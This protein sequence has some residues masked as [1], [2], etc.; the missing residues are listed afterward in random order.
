MRGRNDQAEQY[1]KRSLEINERYYGPEH[2]VV[3]DSLNELGYLYWVL[4]RYT[5][6]EALQRRE[7]AIRE[8]TLGT[9]HTTLATA[10]KRLA[11][12]L[13]RT[14]RNA[15]APPFA[16]RA[17]EIHESFYGPESEHIE[18][19]LN[20]LAVVLRSMARPAQAEPIYKL[21]HRSRR[22]LAGPGGTRPGDL[23][24]QPGRS[25]HEPGTLWGSRA[26]SRSKPRPR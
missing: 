2:P 24:E 10:F 20:I 26:C 3:A 12:T 22:T 7:I 11:W 14:S 19:S 21:H 9:S 25:L 6:A 5:E 8:K 15:A 1:L 16:T 13:H 23:P 18:Q 17:V 4:A